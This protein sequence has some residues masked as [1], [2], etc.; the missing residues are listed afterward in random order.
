MRLKGDAMELVGGAGVFDYLITD[1]PYPT[2]TSNSL[3]AVSA[4]SDTRLMLDG[5]FQSFFMEVFRKINKN[6]RFA[7]WVFCDWRQVS[8]LSNML[9]CAGYDKQSCLVWDKQRG[10]LSALY[11]PSYEMVL[12]ASNYS[13]RGVYLGRDLI[14]MKRPKSRRHPY[15]KPAELIVEMCHSFPSGRC[16]DPFAGSGSTAEACKTMGWPCTTIEIAQ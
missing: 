2:G 15:E 8:F 14:S 11:H 3:R 12:Y 13:M 16:L 9:R 6:D 1:P 4:V 7:C 10:T 5:M